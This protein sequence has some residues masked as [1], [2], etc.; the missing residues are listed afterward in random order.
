MSK[1]LTK[2]FYWRDKKF[3]TQSELADKAGLSIRI[4]SRAENGNKIALG[5]IKA[6]AKALEVKPE[7]LL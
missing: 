3:L 1:P 5:S 4:I 6:I 2:L 7:A